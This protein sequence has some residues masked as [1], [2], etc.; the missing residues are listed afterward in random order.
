MLVGKLDIYKIHVVQ[1]WY[2]M[3]CISMHIRCLRYCVRAK[4]RMSPSGVILINVHM[5]G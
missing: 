3:V 5:Y 4:C 2:A 1:H